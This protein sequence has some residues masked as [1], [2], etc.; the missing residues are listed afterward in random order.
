[1]GIQAPL[2]FEDHLPDRMP[3][4]RRIE[5]TARKVAET[6]GYRE[7]RTPLLESTELF[8]R[9]VGEVT[10]IVEKEMFTFDKGEKDSL[11]LRPELTASFVRA[12]VE[13]GLFKKKA[14]QKLF[15]VGANFRKERPQKGRLRQ[16]HQFGVEAL[17]ATD[18]LLDAETVLLALRFLEELGVPGVK[19]KV[20]SIG[21]PNCRPKYR[22]ALK[23][24]FAPIIGQFC[25]N[26]RR[27]F[28][29]NVFRIL[30]CKVEKDVAL[31]ADAPRVQDSLCAD[32]LAHDKA[33]V[34][35]LTRAGCDHKQDPRL[36]RGFDYYTRTVYEFTASGLGAQ[37]AIGG[38]GR[39]DNLIEEMGGDKAGAVGFA[40]GLERV[41][42][43]LEAA[44]KAPEE[45]WF[46]TRVFVTHIGPETRGP[47][48][49]LV[50]QLRGEGVA[51]DMDYEGR[52]LKAQM[53]SANRV[54]APWVVII[55]GDELAKG[56]VKLRDMGKSEEVE[57]KPGELAGRVRE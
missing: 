46:S 8:I 42:I 21:C 20:N 26:C 27:R 17:G 12:C 23:A 45:E 32:C 34:E 36:V 24:K 31:T 38:G 5:E 13:H 22:D 28:D 56:V 53:R 1:M 3:I 19:T 14:F 6:Y 30:D 39:Y 35:A 33:F 40:I 43:A 47:A 7:M 54:K 44:G 48:F 2:G 50:R 51:A 9:S 41:V 25:E 16:F 11:T 10:D 55:G 37:D 52:S 4:W 15:Y 57:V 29:R 49:D 18:P